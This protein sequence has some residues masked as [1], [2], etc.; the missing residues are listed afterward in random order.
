M[1]GYRRDDIYNERE[2]HK[3]KGKFWTKASESRTRLPLA[4]GKREVRESKT[5]SR[6][7]GRERRSSSGSLLDLAEEIMVASR[8]GVLKS[9]GRFKTRIT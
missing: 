1:C 8:K 2:A 7:G 3:G 6:E 5:L 9:E 4:K